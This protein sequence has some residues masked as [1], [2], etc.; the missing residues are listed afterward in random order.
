M[1][2]LRAGQ[3]I[4]YRSVCFHLRLFVCDED[5]A[6]TSEWIFRNLVWIMGN[7][8]SENQLHFGTDLKQEAD[9]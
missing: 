7:G 6:K 9:Q 1:M 4:S 8:P 5:Y 3:K 2:A